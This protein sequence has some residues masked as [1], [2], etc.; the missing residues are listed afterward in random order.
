MQSPWPSL[1]ASVNQNRSERGGAYTVKLWA[2][3]MLFVWRWRLGYWEWD[4]FWAAF[5][6]R[7]PR[8]DCITRDPDHIKSTL[9]QWYNK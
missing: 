9:S 5:T 6:V 2:L 8:K 1:A 3:K 4:A 7:C